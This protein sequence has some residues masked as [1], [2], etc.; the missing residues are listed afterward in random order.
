MHHTTEINKPPTI[1]SR[2]SEIIGYEVVQLHPYH[3]E[4][5]AIEFI[6]NMIKCCIAVKNGLQLVAD[7]E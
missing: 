7:I 3:R 4:L 1:A 5:N 6:R 2:E